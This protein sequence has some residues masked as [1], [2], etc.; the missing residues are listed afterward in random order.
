MVSNAGG[1]VEL[2]SFCI[3]A[4]VAFQTPPEPNKLN[5]E[6]LPE[7]SRRSFNCVEKI[8]RL[9]DLTVRNQAIAQ[10]L[11]CDQKKVSPC[12]PSS[13]EDFDSLLKKLYCFPVLLRKVTNHTRLDENFRQANLIALQS[14]QFVCPLE[15]VPS[16]AE[17][18]EPYKE[19]GSKLVNQGVSSREHLL[20]ALQSSQSPCKVPGHSQGVAEVCAGKAGGHLIDGSRGGGIGYVAPAGHQ[21]W[22]QNAKPEDVVS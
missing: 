14:S 13:N 16:T 19:R 22:V 7:C 1:L 20:S 2:A 21:T 11:E 5:G 4:G 12:S 8:S 9:G 15:F 6:M 10:V 18:A 3:R 17:V